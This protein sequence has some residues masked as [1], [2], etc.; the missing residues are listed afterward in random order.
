MTSEKVD[1]LEIIIVNVVHY[2]YEIKPI[3]LRA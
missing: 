1:K 3:N 2:S